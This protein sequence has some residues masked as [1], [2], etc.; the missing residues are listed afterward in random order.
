MQMKE[1]IQ[2]KHRDYSQFSSPAFTSPFGADPG[3][4]KGPVC[5]PEEHKEF[6]ADVR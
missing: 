2:S 3:P 6:I 4:S 1:T 5:V